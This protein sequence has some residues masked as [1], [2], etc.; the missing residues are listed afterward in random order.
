VALHHDSDQFRPLI[1]HGST[2]DIATAVGTR[3]EHL[4][5]GCNGIIVPKQL[6]QIPK[7]LAFLFLHFLEFFGLHVFGQVVVQPECLQAQEFYGSIE[8][9]F[10][11][12]EE[13]TPAP[14]G[15]DCVFRHL[16]QPRRFGNRVAQGVHLLLRLDR[17]RRQNHRQR[18]GRKL[19]ELQQSQVGLFG[20]GDHTSLGSRSRGSLVSLE[21]G[22]DCPVFF[23]HGEIDRHL[24]G[25][26]LVE[27]MAGGDYQAVGGVNDAACLIEFSKAPFD[28]NQ[29]GAAGQ[30]R[31]DFLGRQGPVGI[32]Y[33]W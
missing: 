21:V 16:P 28:G 23:E 31:G 10:Q 20:S 8:Q 15:Q 9:I 22:N 12:I 4:G 2:V 11:I 6:I 33:D 3:G 30:F 24:G 1:D 25:I 14:F 7:H 32:R 27:S 18:L 19:I 17:L 5:V 26:L 29:H 13:I